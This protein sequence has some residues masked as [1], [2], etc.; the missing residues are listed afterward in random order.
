MSVKQDIT[1]A[2]ASELVYKIHSLMEAEGIRPGIASVLYY[3][4][5]L[6]ICLQVWDSEEEIRDTFDHMKENAISA[7]KKR[8][9][10][11]NKHD[12]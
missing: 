4:A 6:E 7:W 1:Q 8:Q 3:G 2:K 11:I 10:A 12:V 9:E 5:F